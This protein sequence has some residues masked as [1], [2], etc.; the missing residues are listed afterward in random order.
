M[1]NAPGTKIK[2]GGTIC[3]PQFWTPQ[4]GQKPRNFQKSWFYM[5][6]FVQWAKAQNFKNLFLRKGGER[7]AWD[8]HP[9]SPTAVTR[10]VAQQQQSGM[11][12]DVSFLP[13]CPQ[14]HNTTNTVLP[15]SWNEEN[16]LNFRIANSNFRREADENCALPCYYAANSANFLPAFRDNLRIVDILR[17]SEMYHP[18]LYLT[19]WRRNFPLNFSTP[20]I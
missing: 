14:R 17:M 1:G 5:I 4:N 6:L 9:S 3:T 18:T 20:C 7:V 11:T 12:N 8:H 2:K 19:L 10:S 16:S 15:T 13:F